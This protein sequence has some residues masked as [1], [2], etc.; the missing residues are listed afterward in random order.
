[1]SCV[2]VR[3]CIT[4]ICGP[5]V[6][7]LVQSALIQSALIHSLLVVWYQCVYS[8]STKECSQNISKCTQNAARCGAVVQQTCKDSSCCFLSGLAVNKKVFTNREFSFTLE[9]DIY[10]RYQSFKDQ[11]DMEQEIR[12]RNPHKIDIGAV[13]SAK[14]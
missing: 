14:V 11:K 4:V 6:C 2:C 7:A 13:F 12:K 9:G 8:H 5:Q 3:A 1:M 10:V